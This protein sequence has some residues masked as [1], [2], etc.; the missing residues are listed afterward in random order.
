MDMIGHDN[1]SQQTIAVAIPEQQ[2]LLDLGR[3]I[4]G[5]QMTGPISGIE[6]GSNAPTPDMLRCIGQSLKY[7]SREAISKTERHRLNDSRRIEMGKIAP[8]VPTFVIHP[9]MRAGRPRS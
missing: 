6:M 2:S 4:R 5:R 8:R 1:P 3:Y 7:R 9:I